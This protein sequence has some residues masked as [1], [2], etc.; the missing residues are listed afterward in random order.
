MSDTKGVP[1]AENTPAIAASPAV[2]SSNG[3]G[4][5]TSATAPK[6]PMADGNPAFRMM[7]LPRL[8]LPSRNWLIFLSLSGSIASAI[9]YDKYETRRT[10]QKWCDVVSHLAREPLDTK[11]MPRKLTIY[12]AAPPGDG[13]RSA[14]EHFHNYVKPILVAGAMDWDVVEGRKEGD[15]R[16][17]TAERVRRKRRRRGEGEALEEE[18]LQKEYAMELMRERNGTGEY[19]GVSG[20]L[21]VGRHTWKEY[22]RGVHEGWLGPVDQPTVVPA[23]VEGAEDSAAATHVPG[24]SSLGDAAAKGAAKVLAPTPQPDTDISATLDA[25]SNSPTALGTPTPSETLPSED[26]PKEEEK[27]S[28]PRN[29]APYLLPSAYPT[30]TLS[31]SIPE[32]IG[33]SIILPFPHILGVRN[34]HVRIY[35][36]LTRRRLADEIGRDVAAAVLG[37]S[38]RSFDAVPAPSRTEDGGAGDSVPEQTAVLAREEGE[39]WKSVHRAREEG[40]ESVWIEGMALDER[41][42]GRMRRFELSAAEEDRAKRIAA[43]TG[44]VVK[45]NADE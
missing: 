45:E 3:T 27:A 8:R 44:V 2:P 40:E 25:D 33:P 23:V 30:A 17:K 22:V 42:A 14:R 36:F 4:V 26:A 1:P 24:H 6:K 20:D 37:A 32:V 7:G 29:P 13:L 31:P 21:V 5:N 16:H 41:V 39:W 38:Y 18:E 43:G 12:L 9:L 10:K 11:N 19:P 35:R 28:K 34:T 15:V